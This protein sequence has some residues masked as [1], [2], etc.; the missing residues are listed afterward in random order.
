MCVTVWLNV[1]VSI[2]ASSLFGLFAEM[3]PFSVAADGKTL[4]PRAATWTVEYN[5]VFV[6]NPVGVGFSFTTSSDGFVSNETQVGADLYSFTSQFFTIFSELASNPLY[7][8][9]E[10]YGGKVGREG[11]KERE[12]GRGRECVCVG[13][14]VRD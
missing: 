11:E 9:G 14:R 12:R 1:V 2:G 4:V 8:T 3:G 7:I 5:M 13:L 6:D 10:S